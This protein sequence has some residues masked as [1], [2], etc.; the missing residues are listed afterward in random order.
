[1]NL[2]ESCQLLNLS[3]QLN[4][5]NLGQPG[6]KQCLTLF[7]LRCKKWAIKEKHLSKNDNVSE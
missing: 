1:M 6:T 2:V 3:T 5:T 4:N 7:S